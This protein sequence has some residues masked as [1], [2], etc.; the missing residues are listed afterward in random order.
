MK[1]FFNSIASNWNEINT[2]PDER[3]IDLVASLPIRRGDKVLDCAC[4]TGRISHLLY[5]LS[6]VSVDGL[7]FAENMISYGRENVKEGV[8]FIVG[9][10]Y[11]HEGL[12]DVI[13]VFDAYP[14]FLKVTR[15]KE[16]VRRNLKKGGYLC[17]IH[18]CSRSSLH[19]FHNGSAFKYS[20]EILSP[21]EEAEFFD[22]FS[23]VR[24]FENANS[25]ELILIRE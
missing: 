6:G 17:I 10:F 18:D 3:I 13:V 5:K 4:G 16:A 2:V 24:A 12:Y 8:N 25:Y 14:H 23:V 20:R 11:E 22:G 19:E 1:D 15:F 9:D 21:H 7:D